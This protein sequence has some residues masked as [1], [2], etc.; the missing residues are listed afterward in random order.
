MK[1]FRAI[2]L[3]RAIAQLQRDLLDLRLGDAEQFRLLLLRH[4]L[5]GRSD[6][7]QGHAAP[8]PEG[9]RQQPSRR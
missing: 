9:D 4:L 2:E 1:R 7:K 5:L 6:L 3:H 8:H